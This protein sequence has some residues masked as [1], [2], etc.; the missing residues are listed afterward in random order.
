MNNQSEK[1][2]LLKETGNT[3]FRDGEYNTAL[4]YYSEAIVNLLL[5]KEI[6]PENSLFYSN[7]A[8]C[9]KELGMFQQALEF[10]DKAVQIDENN[11]KAHLLLGLCLCELSKERESHDKISTAIKRLQKALSLCAGQNKQEFES[12]IR[13]YIKRALKLEYYLSY[14]GAQMSKKSSFNKSVVSFLLIK[15]VN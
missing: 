10:A 9:L 14:E 6:D 8:R 5:I 3:F 12:K 15:G 2:D 11:I 4:R 1:G 13:Q 7:K